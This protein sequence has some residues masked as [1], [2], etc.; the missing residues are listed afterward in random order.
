MECTHVK[1]SGLPLPHHQSNSLLH[2]RRRLLGE[3]QRK[4]PRRVE[5]LLFEDIC[6]PARQNPGLSRPRTSN[7]KHRPVH[8]TDSSLLLAVQSF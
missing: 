6:Y 1:P 7:Y 4:D 8:T 3:G 2:F 5:I